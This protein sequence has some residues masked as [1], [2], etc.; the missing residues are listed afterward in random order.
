M[1]K[2]LLVRYGFCLLFSTA[3]AFGDVLQCDLSE[4]R[5]LPGLKASLRDDKLAVEWDGARQQKLRVAFALENAQPTIR[6]M[7]VRPSGGEWL[8]LGANLRPEFHVTT[9]Q[10]RISEQQLAPLRALGVEITPEVIESEKWKAFWDAPLVVPGRENT[11]PG[12][13]RKPEEIRRANSRFDTKGCKVKTDGARLEISFPGL[14]LG[15]FSGNLQFTVYRGTNL[16]RQEAVAKTEEPSVAY[17]YAGGLK[18]FQ[19]A[20]APRVVWQDTARAWQKFEFGGALNHDPVALR[21]R[22]RLAIIET[23]RGSLAVFPPSHKFFFAREIELNLGFVWYRKDD[24]ASFSV[25]VRQADREE[26]FRP[27]GFSDA[28]WQKRSNQARSFSAANFALFNAPPGTWQRMALY[29]YLSPEGSRAAQE[30]VMAFTHGDRFKPLPGYQVAISHFHTAFTEQAS[31]AG[32]LDFQPPW[33]PAFRSL[34]VNIAMMSDFHGDGNERD[35][36]EPRLKDLATYF[37][38]CRRHS[39]KEFLIL[40]GEEPNAH[41]G[42]HYTIVFPKP[43]YWT[44]VRD[45]GQPFTENHA[46][47]GAVYHTGSRGDMLEMLQREKGLV[48]QAHPRTKGSTYYPDA[49][50]DMP[51]FRSDR[52]LGGS[53]QSLPVDLSEKRICESRCFGLLDEMNNWGDAKYMLAEGDTYHKY[54]EDELFPHLIVNYIKLTKLPA[55]DDGWAP[56]TDALRAGEFFVSTG[57]VLIP[58]FA[59]QGAGPKRTIAAKVEWTFPLDFVEVVWGDGKTTSRQIIPATELPALGEKQFSIP[60]DAEGKKWVRFAAWDSAGNGAFTQP[61][62]LR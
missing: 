43:V 21:A 35:A 46:S 57:E 11:N 53:Y 62:H 32:T 39:D 19:V 30:A 5:E 28:L 9:G 49:V 2:A 10:R 40:P 44:R 14:S 33:I 42:G 20:Q 59:V 38:V 31:D 22:N 29:F 47:H 60:F 55:F 3:L 56:V 61:V 18:G 7:A 8:V 1:S 12:L 45:D 48:W 27:F 4:Y 15:V 6:E 24:A 23:G 51:H 17:N 36:G 50:K 52:F 26:P 54:P 34:G 25:G 58:E 37:E 16:L 41:L 13:P